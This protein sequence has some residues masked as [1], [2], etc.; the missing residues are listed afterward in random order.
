MIELH[1][2][3]LLSDGVLLPSEA[4]Q[5]A[6]ADGLAALAITDHVDIG[7][8]VRVVSELQRI[9]EEMEGLLAVRLIVGAEVTHVPP[10]LIARVCRLARTH[11]AQLVL[12][13]GETLSEPVAPGTNRAAL[14]ADCDILA[15]P[16][17][18]EERD[19][20]LAARRGIY[21]ELSGRKGHCLGNG[22]LAF[23]AR[24]ANARMVLNSDA[25]VPGDIMSARTRYSIGR[26]AGLFDRE[27]EET[28]QN[29]RTI[30][31]R[32]QDGRPVRNGE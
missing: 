24:Q 10:A 23:L 18:L 11:G 27:V 19:A 15:H 20:E 2:H 9:R 8:V 12:V 26:G 32:C 6:Q 5:R 14:E 30:A 1:S 22:H 29:M 25:H 16:G 4:L 31:Q 21:L 3:T 13:H 17:L 7:N 28:L